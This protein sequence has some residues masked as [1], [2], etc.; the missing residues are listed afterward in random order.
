VAAL[1]GLLLVL[2]GTDAAVSTLTVAQPRP[3]QRASEMVSFWMRERGWCGRAGRRPAL[4]AVAATVSVNSKCLM[5]DR[6]G[7]GRS[8][9]EGIR[10]D[11]DA[12]SAWHGSAAHA[13]SGRQ[14]AAQPGVEIDLP[15]RTGG[16]I[17]SR[18][19]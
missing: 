8:A 7:S 1:G 6:R 10:I 19:R 18:S 3:H 5:A 4:K 16:A 15:Q 11:L 12:T 13:F 9:P 14:E 17:T 2:L